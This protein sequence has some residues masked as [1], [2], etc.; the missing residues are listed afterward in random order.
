M[1]NESVEMN[2]AHEARAGYHPGP[3]SSDPYAP[4]RTVDNSTRRAGA[5]ELLYRRHSHALAGILEVLST[6]T[7]DVAPDEN[8][9]H[10]FLWSEGDTYAHTMSEDTYAVLASAREVRALPEVREVDY[11]TLAGHSIVQA[12]IDLMA[13]RALGGTAAFERLH[14]YWTDAVRELLHELV[15]LGYGLGMRAA[16]TLKDEGVQS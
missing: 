2:L 15:R 14:I 6:S 4:S 16:L 5:A 7:A 10:G 3:S 13:L 11:A 1:D 9:P 8:G 12:N